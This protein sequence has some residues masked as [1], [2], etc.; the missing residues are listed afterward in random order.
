M[1]NQT[2][3]VLQKKMLL[4][5]YNYMIMDHKIL[6]FPILGVEWQKMENPDLRMSVGMGNE[7]KGVRVKRIDP[8]APAF[9]VLSSSDIILSFDGVNVANDGTGVHYFLMGDFLIE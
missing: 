4:Y 2:V 3:K 5:L 1:T 6:G 7:H 8:T 9:K